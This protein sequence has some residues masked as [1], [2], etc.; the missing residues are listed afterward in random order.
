[1]K[2]SKQD[3][4]NL[5]IRSSDELIGNTDYFDKLENPNF[6]ATCYKHFKTIDIQDFKINKPPTTEYQNELKTLAVNPIELF[7]KNVVENN[8]HS[9]HVQNY[10]SSVYNDYKLFCK[11]RG[12]E[13]VQNN[14][15]FGVRLKR[16]AIKG[17][18]KSASKTGCF[19]TFD[20][21]GLKETFKMNDL[22]D[23]NITDSDSDCED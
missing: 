19:Y 22:S 6:I 9:Y 7:V 14:I 12:F 21:D 11:S 13:F 15:K 3:R 2:T 23:G 20:I 18:T 8:F 16:L 5:I 4:R 17:V 10:G 1:M